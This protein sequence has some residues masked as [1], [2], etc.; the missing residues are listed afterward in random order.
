MTDSENQFAR[1]DDPQM[2][3]KGGSGGLKIIAIIIIVLVLVGGCCVG[4][5]FVLRYAVDGGVGMAVKP[6]IEDTPAVETYIG[7]IDDISMAWGQTAQSGSDDRV[8]LDVS[9]DKGTGLL[10]IKQG[11]TGLQNADWAILEIDGTSYVVFGTPP[12]DLGA[13]VLPGTNAEGD[14]PATPAPPATPDTEETGDETDA[15]SDS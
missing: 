10:V 3:T 6:Q 1:T 12:E 4:G 14:D 7:S 5:I 11:S 13:T 15:S 8:A 9:G 2:A